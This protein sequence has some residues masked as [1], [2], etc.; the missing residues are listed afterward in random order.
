MFAMFNSDL[1]LYGGFLVITGDGQ[2]YR[3]PFMGLKGDYTQMDV[4]G[5]IGLGSTNKSETIL[6]ANESA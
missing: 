4:L 5:D 2:T 3:V 6:S 1:G